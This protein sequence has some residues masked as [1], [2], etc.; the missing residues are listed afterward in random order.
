MRKGR[1]KRKRWKQYMIEL[2]R[3]ES[4]LEELGIE[5]EGEVDGESRGASIL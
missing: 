2:Y 3:S 4:K 1:G 5:E